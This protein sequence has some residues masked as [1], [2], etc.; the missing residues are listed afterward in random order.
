M[1]NGLIARRPWFAFT[2]KIEEANFVWTQLKRLDFFKKQKNQIQ[3]VD[4]EKNSLDKYIEGSILT[5][6]DSNRFKS[7]LKVHINSEEHCDERMLP[8]AKNFKYGTCVKV[9]EIK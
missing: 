9:S 6:T 5:E 8:R 7:Y 2:D 4:I 3:T 1:L